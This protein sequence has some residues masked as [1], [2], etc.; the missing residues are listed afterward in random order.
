MATYQLDEEQGEAIQK[1]GFTI[2]KYAHG[3]GILRPDQKL[4]DDL[5]AIQELVTAMLAIME[6]GKAGEPR[7]Q[8]IQSYLKEHVTL[9]LLKQW[10]DNPAYLAAYIVALERNVF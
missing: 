3:L 10:R 2:R 1:L 8:E 4:I 9:T 6:Q 7:Q 5:Q